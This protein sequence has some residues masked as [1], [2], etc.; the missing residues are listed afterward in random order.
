MIEVLFYFILVFVICFNN[1]LYDKKLN[2]KYQNLDIY[3]INNWECSLEGKVISKVPSST[4][5]I[6]MWLLGL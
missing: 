1:Y 3:S 2:I 5:M 6:L 4:N